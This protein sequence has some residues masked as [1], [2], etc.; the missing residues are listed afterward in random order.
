MKTVSQKLITLALAGTIATVLSTTSGNTATM[1]MGRWET[2]ATEQTPAG[3]TPPTVDIACVN[4]E[5]DGEKLVYNDI[6]SD[7]NCKIIKEE[8]RSGTLYFEMHCVEDGIARVQKGTIHSTASTLNMSMEII[9]D[10][11]DSPMIQEMMG[12]VTSMKT[13]FTVDSKRTGACDG[14]EPAFDE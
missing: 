1:E 8:H 5:L 14:S 6:K 2:T 7:P 10:L 12:G 4:K 13:T 3:S 11:S 9:I